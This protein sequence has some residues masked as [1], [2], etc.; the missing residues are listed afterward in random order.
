MTAI[1]SI[2]ATIVAKLLLNLSLCSRKLA[3]GNKRKA[4]NNENRNGAKI[5]LPK[6]AK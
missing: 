2:T 6:M 3:N 1:I 4:I 5:V